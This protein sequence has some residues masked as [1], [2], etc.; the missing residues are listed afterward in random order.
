[1]PGRIIRTDF[2]LKTFELATWACPR[3]IPATADFLFLAT[4]RMMAADSQQPAHIIRLFFWHQIYQLAIDKL[5]KWP[6]CIR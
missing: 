1:M 5:K 2:V 3:S 6:N 4:L